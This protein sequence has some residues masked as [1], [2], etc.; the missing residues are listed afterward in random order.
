MAPEVI[1]GLP[2][3]RKADIYS[4]G[5]L[6]YEVVTDSDPYPDLIKGKITKFEFQNL[7]INKKYRPKFTF[8]VKENLKKL[9]EKCWSDDLNERPT[10]D[11]IYNKLTNSYKDFSDE[12][13]I[14]DDDD[15]NYFLDDVDVNEVLEY[16]NLINNYS[17]PNENLLV[18]IQKLKNQ[19]TENTK[20][21]E[22]ENKLELENKQLKEDLTK[23][24]KK[25]EK[26]DKE[27]ETDNYDFDKNTIELKY[28]S[29]QFQEI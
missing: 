4:F 2:Y 14:I 28:P 5:I 26:L 10:F 27:K 6:M 1:K 7:V 19:V 23:L 20:K 8:Y 9:I 24:E 11:E 16:I 22:I 17:N 25:N 29:S 3:D 21:H 13:V 18:E 12:K 15:N